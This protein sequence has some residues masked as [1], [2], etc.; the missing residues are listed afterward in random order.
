M[1]RLTLLVLLVIAT[2]QLFAQSKK[3]LLEDAEIKVASL[4]EDNAMLQRQL[5][6]ANTEKE[7]YFNVYKSLKSE[8]I[9]YD[10]DP[11]KTAFLIDSLETSWDSLYALLLDTK[12]QLKDSVTT[13]VALNQQLQVQIDSLSQNDSTLV[14]LNQPEQVQIGGLLQNSSVS[15]KDAMVKELKQLKELY[16]EEI[17]SKELFEKKRDQIMQKWE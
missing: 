16:V 4:T 10:F 11:T 17:I 14:D 9:E 2:T 6:S 3:E 1:K 13:L 12:A 8:L 7:L 5:Y 15:N